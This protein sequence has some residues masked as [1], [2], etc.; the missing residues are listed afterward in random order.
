MLA[1]VA[2]E[3][4]ALAAGMC[5]CVPADVFVEN[6]ALRLAREAETHGRRARTV[7]NR[8]GWEGGRVLSHVADYVHKAPPREH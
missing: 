7:K 2:C 1:V 6:G 5:R 3:A 4:S 8:G